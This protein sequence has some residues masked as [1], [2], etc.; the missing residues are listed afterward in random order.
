MTQE[1]EIIAGALI[2]HEIRDGGIVCKTLMRL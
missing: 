1:V 2:I